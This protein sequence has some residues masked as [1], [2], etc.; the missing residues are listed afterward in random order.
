MNTNKEVW[1]KRFQ[2][3]ENSGSTRTDYCR[4]HQIPVSTFDYWRQRIRKESNDKGRDSGLV[5]LPPLIPQ[6]K[7][8]HFTFE[9]PSGHKLH[10]P[11]DYSPDELKQLVSDLN[12]VLR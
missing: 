1:I 3:W 6:S 12:E 9:Y 10:V 5:K 2:D 11:S 7:P 4:K 8:I